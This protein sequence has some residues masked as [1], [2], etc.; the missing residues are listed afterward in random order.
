MGEVTEML[1]VRPSLIRFWGTKFSCLKPK[2]NNKGNRMFTPEDVANL[3]L[4]YHLVK[5]KKM[6]LEGAAK[7]IKANRLDTGKDSANISALERLQNIRSLLLEIKQNLGGGYDVE[8]DV[9][10]TV[11]AESPAMAEN[12]KAEEKKEE[13]PAPEPE[14]KA[15]VSEEA[16]PKKPAKTRRRAKEQSLF[17]DPEL[18]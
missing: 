13:R 16:K 5:E 8:E 10:Q 7:A 6:T 1:D 17:A 11:P 12:Q 18:F 3:K 14:T 9:P 15:V 2:R 4:I